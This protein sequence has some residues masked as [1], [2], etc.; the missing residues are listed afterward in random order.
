MS[1]REKQTDS[2]KCAT[3]ATGFIGGQLVG[4]LMA[5]GHTVRGTVR[6]TIEDL[7]AKHHIPPTP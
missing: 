2:T 4:R 6:G 5:S 3:G 7:I 1:S